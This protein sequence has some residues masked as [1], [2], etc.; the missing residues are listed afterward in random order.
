MKLE[1]KTFGS[2][3]YQEENILHFPLGLC[4]FEEYTRW[5]LV[6]GAATG[7]VRWLVS[8]Q[9]PGTALPVL[10]PE[11]LFPK[12]AVSGE[13]IPAALREALCWKEKR[14]PLRVYCVAAMPGDV[15]Q[16]T[17]NLGAPVLINP[18][19]CR[20][21]QVPAIKKYPMRRQAYREF[22]SALEAGQC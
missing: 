6:G 17:V 1:T 4:G 18:T 10:R 2:I 22:V 13:S 11:K 15:Q 7:P 8:V 12:Y 3:E 14:P 5:L 20:G 16:M 21:V 9:A 19:V